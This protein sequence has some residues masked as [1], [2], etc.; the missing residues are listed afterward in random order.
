[1]THADV[2]ERD[3]C[4]EQRGAAGSKKRTSDCHG[5][6]VGMCSLTWEDEHQ[7]GD[8][9]AGGDPSLPQHGRQVGGL[10]PGMEGADEDVW[11]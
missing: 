9:Q 5:P 2:A 1:V 11:L 8:E 4:P 6:P 3:E 10:S 7:K